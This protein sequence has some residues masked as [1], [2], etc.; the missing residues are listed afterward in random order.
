[1]SN[2]GHLEKVLLEIGEV[3]K[4][5]W[6][7]NYNFSAVKSSGHAR[8]SFMLTCGL[9]PLPDTDIFVH[10]ISKGGWSLFQNDNRE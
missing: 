7:R 8:P 6:H 5:T 4:K 2:K 10:G 1:M 3:L 9:L